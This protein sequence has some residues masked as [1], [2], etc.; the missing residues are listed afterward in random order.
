[1]HR[2]LSC[3][4]PLRLFACIAQ[5]DRFLNMLPAEVLAIVLKHLPQ[6]DIVS[7][8]LA[9]G[10]L[11][12][13]PVQGLDDLAN[14]AYADRER[15]GITVEY[16][17]DQLFELLHALLKLSPNLV[18]QRIYFLQR[19]NAADY[20]NDWRDSIRFT[21]ESFYSHVEQEL[22]SG[23]YGQPSYHRVP[24]PSRYWINLTDLTSTTLFRLTNAA[25]LD[26]AKLPPPAISPN[27]QGDAIQQMV[28]LLVQHESFNSSYLAKRD[29]GTGRMG[30]NMFNLRRLVDAVQPW[31]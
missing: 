15:D 22:S 18:Q 25:L 26:I 10:R 28:R 21:P 27:C 19:D 3:F 6:W 17:K 16:H 11:A 31:K 13:D 2:N 30:L 1:M 7:M 14:Q 8:Q 4:W 9:C 23:W 20:Q 12:T 24:S 5:L 29:A